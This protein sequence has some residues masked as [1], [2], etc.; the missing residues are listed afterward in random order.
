MIMERKMV[1]ETETVFLSNFDLLSCD[2]SV[3][4]R[5][6]L[7]PLFLLELHQSTSMI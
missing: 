6:D 1:P 3:E 2:S 5:G 4:R 7:T